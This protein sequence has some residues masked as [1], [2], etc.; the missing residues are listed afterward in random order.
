MDPSCRAAGRRI[1]VVLFNLGGPDEPDDVE[2][3]LRNL[4][5]D[6]AIIDAPAVLRRPLAWAIARLRRRSARAN[7]AE[8]GGGSPLL[9]NTWAQAGALEAVLKRRR[10][11]D[12]VLVTIAMRHWRPTSREAL[13]ILASFAPDQ[14]AVVPLYPQF[15]T[16]TTGSSLGDW[17]HAGGAGAG[18]CCWPENAGL[19][20]AHAEAILSTWIDAGRPRVRLLFSAHGLPERVVRRGDP[21]PWQVARTCEAVVSRLPGVWGW[22][23]CYQSRVGPVA[24][25]RPSTPEAI[26]EAGKEG[27]GVILD[28][29]SFVSEHVE[30]LVELDRDYAALARRLGTPVYLRVPAVGVARAFIEGLADVAEGALA[31]GGGPGDTPC[32]EGFA[33]CGRRAACSMKF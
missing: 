7:Y 26:A 31:S 28:P 3:F 33:G 13:D 32:P 27:L 25:L 23:L 6:R 17:R 19:V 14:V 9:A 29:I 15:S 16:T 21:Y 24:W 11:R 18:V 5:G 10:P 2:P 30:T 8:M 4:F 12:D 20:A 1:A 22:K